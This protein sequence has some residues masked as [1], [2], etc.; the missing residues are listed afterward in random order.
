[1]KRVFF[2]GSNKAVFSYLCRREDIR[3]VGAVVHAS[4]AIGDDW[5]DEA[6]RFGIELSEVGNDRE[7]EKRLN[8]S[9]PV[10]LGVCAGFEMIGVEVASI[11]EMGFVNIHPSYLPWYRGANP[12]FHVIMNGETWSGVTIHEIDAGVDSGLI[13]GQRKFEVLVGDDICSLIEKANEAAVELLA[14][15]LS[16][17]LDGTIEKKANQGGSYYPPIRKRQRI[18][19][20]MGEEYIR[21]LLRT[22][23]CYGGCLFASESGDVEVDAIVESGGRDK[24]SR[25]FP[26]ETAEGSVLYLTF[27]G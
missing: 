1:M 6:K 3:L 2:A 15:H 14:S 21:R 12:F 9:A 7:L 17:I 13:L 22:Q 8:E 25:V 19:P 16:A 24:P 4:S 18:E 26:V 11:P 23:T 5:F 27:L 10:D 20:G